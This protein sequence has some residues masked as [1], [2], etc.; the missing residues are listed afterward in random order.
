MRHA[1]GH[2]LIVVAAK[3]DNCS[4]KGDPRDHLT[5]VLRARVLVVLLFSSV[6]VWAEGFF[7]Q[8]T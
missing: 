4:Q 5:H 2:A 8:L 6:S 1:S 7:D 3:R